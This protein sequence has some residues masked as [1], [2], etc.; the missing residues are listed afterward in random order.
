MIQILLSK[1]TNVLREY[2]NSQ[3]YTNNKTWLP[4]NN[5]HPVELSLWL[6]E[7]IMIYNKGDKRTIATHSKSLINRLGDYIENGLINHED[8]CI[9]II[10]PCD[11]DHDFNVSES[12]FNEEGDLVDWPLG[13]FNYIPY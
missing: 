11:E 4:E 2:Y 5:K 3:T 10:E 13:F 9:Y 7:Q 1:N 6:D 8:V 12:R